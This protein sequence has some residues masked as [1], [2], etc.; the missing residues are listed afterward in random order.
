MYKLKNWID[1]D[2]LNPTL[3][4]NPNA[5]NYLIEH[6]HLINIQHM[7]YNENACV[8]LCNHKIEVYDESYI[9]LLNHNAGFSN[10][11]RN[12]LQYINYDILSYY[13][14]GI[15]FIDE[16]IKNNE[17]D[18]I[19]WRGLSQNPAA[20]HII[21]DE[22]YYH[23]IDKTNITYNIH[24]ADFIQ[25]NLHDIEWYDICIQPHLI[26]LIEKNQDNIH[27]NA[28][29]I[30][31]NATHLLKNNLNRIHNRM[32]YF[33][34]KGFELLLQIGHVFLNDEVYHE[35]IIFDYFTH[36]KGNNDQ[37]D[38]INYLARY[39]HTEE[40]MNYLKNNNERIDYALLSKNPN[41]FE[42]DYEMMKKI[43]QS[44]PWYKDIYEKSHNMY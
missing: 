25:N 18:K 43:R 16:L 4:S 39:G 35:N 12:N 30:N 38:F 5:V 41:I 44:L 13:P 20:M 17:L 34:K 19:Y 6:N 31:Q 27:W 9:K 22:K 8:I 21:N 3:S 28:L 32:L 37:F 2:R 11:L 7:R 26:D 14:H 10:F 24:A 36:C 33:N 23:Y 15:E 29:S 1:T 42:Y 40:H